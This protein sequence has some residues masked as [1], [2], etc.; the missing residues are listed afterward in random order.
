[1]MAKKL[2]E[3]WLAA[4]VALILGAGVA[5]GCASKSTEASGETHFVKCK[6]NADCTT[7]GDSCQSGECKPDG[8]N[9]GGGGMPGT[10]GTG[11]VTSC[12]PGCAPAYG[13]PVDDAR[14]CVDTTK[15]ELIGCYCGC[16]PGN[17]NSAPV[18][19]CRIRV[20]DET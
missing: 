14:S 17:C 4:A 20:P 7:A 19:H 15:K 8:G 13:Y 9:D 1:M 16:N 10:G 3:R 12:A 18:Q 2:H 6:T 11:G 5:F